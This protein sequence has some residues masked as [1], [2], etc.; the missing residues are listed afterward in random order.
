MKKTHLIAIAIIAV[1]IGLL[2]SLSGDVSKYATFEEAGRSGERVKIAGI[3]SKDKAMTYDPEKDAN[4]FSF[5]LKDSEGEE[6]EVVLL[7]GKPQDFERSE[8]IVLTGQM[9]DNRFIA[10]DMLMK[11]P[12]KYK[13]E[14]IFIKSKENTI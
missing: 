9:Q 4:Y 8:Q 5:F 3:L 13:D 1:A 11:C 10:T 12:S 6:R 14:E 7:A 2:I